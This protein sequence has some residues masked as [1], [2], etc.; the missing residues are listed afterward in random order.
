MTIRIYIES[1]ELR[2]Y[3]VPNLAGY[4]AI[5]EIDGKKTTLSK[6]EYGS[7]PLNMT[8]SGVIDCLMAVEKKYPTAQI[9][10]YTTDGNV[11]KAVAGKELCAWKKQGWKR[12][13]LSEANLWKDIL[14]L[15]DTL[16]LKVYRIKRYKN[17]KYFAKGMSLSRKYN[18]N[19]L[20]FEDYCD[21]NHELNN[22]RNLAKLQC[23]R[24]KVAEKPKVKENR[25]S[26]EI[27][28]Y[29]Q[30]I[31]HKAWGVVIEAEGRDAFKLCGKGTGDDCSMTFKAVLEGLKAA[32]WASV[33][34]TP[35]EVYVTDPYVAEVLN[36]LWDRGDIAYADT[37]KEIR[38]QAQRLHPSF[39]RVRKCRN[40]R[41]NYQAVSYFAQD[42]GTAITVGEYS[43]INEKIFLAYRVAEEAGK[44]PAASTKGKETRTENRKPDPE[45]LKSKEIIKIFTD[46]GCHNNGK[47]YAVGGWGAVICIGKEE[48]TFYGGKRETTNSRIEITAV[49]E[50]INNLKRLLGNPTNR[51]EVYSDS[52]YVV[53]AFRKKWLSSWKE[54]GWSRAGGEL[55]NK[56]LWQTLDALVDGLDIIFLSTKGHVGTAGF[57]KA[58]DDF[59]QKNNRKVSINEYRRI[60]DMNDLADKLATRGI[61]EKRRR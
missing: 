36:G 44:K 12:L 51:I 54:R 58:Y 6:A 3:R 45:T 34:G 38:K 48:H 11:K 39:Y 35:V 60:C 1:Y 37:I 32:E 17:K 15:T 7:N 19:Y 33:T 2:E 42:N 55:L 13:S 52:D 30:G 56:D 10:L 20:T 8:L 25:E 29:P 28:I 40:E 27:R 14:T 23:E 16:N 57:K 53:N 21:V 47:I 4:G 43:H 50:A 9:E 49:I 41:L 59:Q 5:L 61:K 46:G 24:I 22:A 26:K 18:G 31:G